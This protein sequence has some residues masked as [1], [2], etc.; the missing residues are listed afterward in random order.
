MQ[1]NMNAMATGPQKWPMHNGQL[2]CPSPQPPKG[3]GG[4]KGSEAPVYL[5][6]KEGS[7][8][9]RGGTCLHLGVLSGF[10]EGGVPP[11]YTSA[12]APITSWRS[13]SLQ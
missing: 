2:P 5:H 11:L 1:R 3:V 13:F 7:Q 9:F 6:K 4:L 12:K 10:S 8:D